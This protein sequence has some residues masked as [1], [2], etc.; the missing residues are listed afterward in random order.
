MTE[1][2][3]LSPKVSYQSARL[4]ET[5]SIK[6]SRNW[7]ENRTI[8]NREIV[9]KIYSAFH[10]WSLPQL[11]QHWSPKGLSSAR[12]E[13]NKSPP[14]RH[15]F[16]KTHFRR[17]SHFLPDT[18]LLKIHFSDRWK[19]PPPER[20][21]Q[22]RRGQESGLH[23]LP[24]RPKAKTPAHLDGWHDSRVARFSV[25]SLRGIFLGHRRKGQ[26]EKYVQYHR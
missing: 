2:R 6:I 8:V 9:G 21:G 25:R 3:L 7:G 13:Q 18:K 24:G 17:S 15:C 16:P 11:Y 12:M 19:N 26:Q 4:T 10:Q 14:L 1:K 23:I 5:H 20:R 22:K